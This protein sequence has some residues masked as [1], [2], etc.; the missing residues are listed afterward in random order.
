MPSAKPFASL[1][2]L[3][4]ERPEFL[5][6]AIESAIFH[7]DEPMEVIVHDDGSTNQLVRDYLWNAHACG[8]I[9]LLMLNPAG[10]NEGQ[11]I[12]LNRMFHAARGDLVIKADQDL[13]F[14][15]RWL[16]RTREIM[17]DPRVGLLGLFRY[18][19]EPVDCARTQISANAPR[20]HG[21]HTHICGS[22][23]AMRRAH[24]RG[25][26]GPFEERNPSFGED[27][28][29]Q[30]RV[31]ASYGFH[32]ALADEDLVVNQGFGIGP[33]TVV[34]GHGQVQAIKPGPKL[35]DGGLDL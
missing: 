26:W 5:A 16:T 8:Q 23:F 14:N 13:V 6:T 35:I 11:G 1:C 19:H 22:G 27:W 18:H 33:S 17:E 9:S 31:S 30:R 29:M 7:A 4:F 25:I 15:P 34:T 24:W 32:C 20:G 21:Y 12:A 28:D 10:H 2:F 3:S